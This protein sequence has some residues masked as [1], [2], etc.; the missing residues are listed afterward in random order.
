MIWQ[1][2]GLI[3]IGLFAGLVIADARKSS[4]GLRRRNL[5][6]ERGSSDLP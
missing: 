4:S 5:N 3:G 2:I 6:G 1:Y